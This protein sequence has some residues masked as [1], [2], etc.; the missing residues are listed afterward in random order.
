MHGGIVGQLGLKFLDRLR[1]LL[2]RQKQIAEPEVHVR[3]VGF[4]FRGP[5]EHLDGARIITHLVERFPG[6]H[7]GFRGVG[8][9]GKDLLV[10]I[11]HFAVLLRPQQTVRQREANGKILRI[12]V[13][14]F[15]EIWSSPPRT[16]RRRS[17]PCREES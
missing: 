2:L 11:K 13:G 14:R 17:A 12:G 6:K 7:V 15:L 9:E 8:I 4:G 5:A 3:L 10:N 16:D 1:I